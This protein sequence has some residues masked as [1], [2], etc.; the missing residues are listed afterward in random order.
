MKLEQ[1]RVQQIMEG[2]KT[3]TTNT[4]TKIETDLLNRK[5]RCTNKLKSA[6]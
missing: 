3:V 1:Y 5:N 2:T 4:I 6:H